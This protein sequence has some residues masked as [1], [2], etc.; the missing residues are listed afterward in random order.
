MKH[1]IALLA[2]LVML[3]GC[4]TPPERVVYNTLAT[5]KTLVEGSMRTAADLLVAGKLK[6]A[7][8]DEIAAV[9]D[10]EFTPAFQTAVT[11]AREDYNAITPARVEVLANQ[12]IN[13]VAAIAQRTN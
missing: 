8:W 3:T 4:K 7:K 2:A 5:T 13:T 12:I 9:Y 1:A 10:Y 11:L 6:E